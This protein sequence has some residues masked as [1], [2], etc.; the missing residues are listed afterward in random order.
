MSRPTYSV[1]HRTQLQL[2]AEGR[3]GCA[4]GSRE[5]YTKA[6]REL[7]QR[8]ARKRTSLNHLSLPNPS[9]Q[10]RTCLPPGDRE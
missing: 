2:L 4:V 8:G 3:L 5:A 9:A 7:G 6:C 1:I 10:G